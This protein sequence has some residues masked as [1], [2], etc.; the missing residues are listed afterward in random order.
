MN[1]SN[2]KTEYAKRNMLNGTPKA[3]NVKKFV[4]RKVYAKC[5]KITDDILRVQVF[6][7]SKGR[8]FEGVTFFFLHEKKRFS[9]KRKVLKEKTLS[10]CSC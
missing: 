9:G 4:K 8:K 7:N 2:R 1:M 5:N 3:L 10:R 6:R